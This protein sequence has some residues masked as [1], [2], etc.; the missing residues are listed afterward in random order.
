MF[1]ESVQSEAQ[2]ALMVSDPI[3]LERPW[4]ALRVRSNFELRSELALANQDFETYVPTFLARRRWSDRTKL[5]PVPLISG[6]VFCRFD[7][8]RRLAVRK[9]TGVVDI[10]GTSDGPLPIDAGEMTHLRTAVWSKI[11]LTPYPYLRTG[12]LVRV[13]RGPLSG[14]EGILTKRR[15]LY[16]IV[17]SITL[18]Q[19]SVAAELDIE[20][21]RP[22]KPAVPSLGFPLLTE[23]LG[24]G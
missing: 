21:V 8:N 4:Y 24:L 17:V 14:V 20:W 10:I 18:L 22:C 1:A 2:T 16:R 13:V 6:Y 9:T 7:Q 19:R 5:V 15:G 11:V 3:D 12:Q 23:S